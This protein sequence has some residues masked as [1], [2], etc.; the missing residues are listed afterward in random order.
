MDGDAVLKPLAQRAVLHLVHV[1]LDAT[2]HS[3]S[4]P[5]P[6][7]QLPASQ[8]ATIAEAVAL[9]VDDELVRQRAMPESAARAVHAALPRGGEH[10]DGVV[11]GVASDHSEHSKREDEGER[12]LVVEVLLRLT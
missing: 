9:A 4:S 10:H 3:S 12:G 1:L 8:K 5:P 6:L 11:G 7:T 2:A